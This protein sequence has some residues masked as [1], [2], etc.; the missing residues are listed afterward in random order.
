[1]PT[2]K[3]PIRSRLTGRRYRLAYV[4][5]CPILEAP[6]QTGRRLQIRFAETGPK[7]RIVRAKRV[8]D[9]A[10][11]SWHPDVVAELQALLIDAMAAHAVT[12]IV[13]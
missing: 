11:V 2:S 7:E 9:W 12:E 8:G 6:Q 13:T 10:P 1:M 3:Y 4:D 5:G